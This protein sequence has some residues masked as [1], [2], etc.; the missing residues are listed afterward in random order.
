ME[1]QVVDSSHKKS[2]LMVA[3]VKSVGNTKTT[4]RGVNQLLL[5]LNNFMPIKLLL[6]FSK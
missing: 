1:E 6:I 2:L 4:E 5:C 3:L